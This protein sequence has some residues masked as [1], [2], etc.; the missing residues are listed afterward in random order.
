MSAKKKKRGGTFITGVD[1][2]TSKICVA[3]AEV[4]DEGIDLLSLTSSPSDGMRKGVVSDMEAATAAIRKALIMARDESGVAV[5]EAILSLS[6][7]HIKSFVESASI[8]VSGRTVSQED[9][10]NVIDAAGSAPL[11]AGKDI[12]HVLPVDFVV[13]GSM[14]IK[15]PLGMPASRL[16]AKVNIITAASEPLHRM[17]VSCEKAGL[18]AS[19]FAVQAIASAESALTG[20]EREMGTALIDIGGGTTDIALFRDGWLLRSAILNI[21]GNHFTNDLTVGFGIPFQEAERI[22]KQFG[23]LSGA[24]GPAEAGDDEID[25]V[26]FHNEVKK[27]SGKMV[28]EI[29]RLRGEELLG[30]IKQE[31][32]RIEGRDAITGAVFTGGCVLIQSFERLAETILAMPVRTGK[33]YLSPKHIYQSAPA[34]PFS[35]GIKE[36]FSGPEYAA[37]IGLVLYGVNSMAETGGPVRDGVF[38]RMSGFFRNI[39]GR[40][41]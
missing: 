6:G 19:D 22:K 40:K 4:T 37:V 10:E 12:I 39:I 29:L 28:C 32:G 5:R 11:S 14:G 21:G 7:G 15:D 41:K 27:I 38:T 20:E 33:P 13:D 23:D 31:I 36:E 9:I 17:I 2:G 24:Y 16:E 34:L 3:V 25:V 30:L 8:A 1:I 35:A 26:G 18:Q